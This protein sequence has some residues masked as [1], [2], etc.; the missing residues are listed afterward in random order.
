MCLLIAHACRLAGYVVNEII[1]HKDTNNPSSCMKH[2][3]LSINW[4]E[5]F[6]PIPFIH[7]SIHSKTMKSI[8]SFLFVMLMM[9]GMHALPIEDQPKTYAMALMTNMDQQ[10]QENTLPDQQDEDDLAWQIYPTMDEQDGI[11]FNEP[12]LISKY[13]EMDYES[14]DHSH[15]VVPKDDYEYNVSDDNNRD[16]NDCY[17]SG[18]GDIDCADYHNDH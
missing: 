16:V 2:L 13:P 6:P 5:N 15:R 18:Y 14:F 17:S 7:S 8:L 1:R 3:N 10:Q 11:Q 12:E 4:N 9:N